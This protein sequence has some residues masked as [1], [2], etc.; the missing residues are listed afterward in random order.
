ML[1]V[2]INAVIVYIQKFKFCARQKPIQGKPTW[3]PWGLKRQ[4]EALMGPKRAET[5]RSKSDIG[6]GM[7]VFN[8]GFVTE[9]DISNEIRPQDGIEKPTWGPTSV[10]NRAE[11]KP[12]S[13]IPTS[14]FQRVDGLEPFAKDEGL[15][16]FAT[17]IKS[18]RDPLII[19]KSSRSSPTASNPELPNVSQQ[20]RKTKTNVIVLPNKI[21]QS[22]SHTRFL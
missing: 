12:T 11:R 17:R 7:S 18:V 21:K 22:N 1:C 15:E 9:S 19:C 4:V 20:S 8:V 6:A 3:A 14:D 13:R 5:G 2:C 16:S 10:F